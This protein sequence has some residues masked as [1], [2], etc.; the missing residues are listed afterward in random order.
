[1]TVS[2]CTSCGAEISKKAESCPKCGEPGKKRTSGVTWFVLFIFIAFGFATISQDSTPVA[3]A[4]ADDSVLQEI[5][6][7]STRIEVPEK[8]KWYT[9]SSIDEMTGKF[10]AYTGM[11]DSTGYPVMTFPYGRAKASLHVGCDKKSEWAYFHFNQSP[12]LAKTQTEDGYNIIKT[13]I[14]WDDKVEKIK[15]RQ[16]W[17]AQSIHFQDG[18]SAIKNIAASSEML[19]K[20]EY[21]GQQPVYFDFSLRGSTK[22]LQDIRA[23]CAQGHK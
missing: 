14:R 7:T 12:N 4:N 13:T 10:S 17:G 23:M 8:P 5:E 22:A 3:S 6:I 1:M 19:L 20:L 18:R 15:L 2:A 9:F 16:D 11:P 21:H